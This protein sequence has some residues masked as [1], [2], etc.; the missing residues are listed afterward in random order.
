MLATVAITVYNMYVAITIRED[1][2]D[3][4]SRVRFL[5]GVVNIVATCVVVFLIPVREGLI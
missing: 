1:R 4:Y 2:M 3:V 5:Y